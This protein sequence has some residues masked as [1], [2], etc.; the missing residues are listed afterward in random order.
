[1]VE[2]AFAVATDKHIFV[3]ISVIVG[4][5]NALAVQIGC[6]PGFFRDIGVRAIAI[7]AVKN[8]VQWHIRFVKNAA[9]R[10]H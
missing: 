3:S 4:H 6:K 5:R 2:H 10:I 8:R 1:V 7:V 9:S